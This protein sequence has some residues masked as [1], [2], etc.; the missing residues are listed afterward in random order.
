VLYFSA[1]NK[2][3]SSADD[4]H[5]DNESSDTDSRR[6]QRVE[7]ATNRASD[8]CVHRHKEQDSKTNQSN[9]TKF[10]TTTFKNRLQNRGT[11]DAPKVH[12]LLVNR[13]MAAQRSDLGVAA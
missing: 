2:G 6:Q 8:I 12:L 3:N 13:F 4:Q 11:T 9:A 5:W 7:T 10:V 1:L